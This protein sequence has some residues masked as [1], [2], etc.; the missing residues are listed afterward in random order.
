MTIPEV[1]NDKLQLFLSYQGDFLLEHPVEQLDHGFHVHPAAG[2]VHLDPIAACALL[3][4]AAPRLGRPVSDILF[5]KHDSSIFRKSY[6]PVW[7]F[8]MMAQFLCAVWPM[9][10][11]LGSSMNHMQG[12]KIV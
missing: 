8:S 1:C 10:N 5:L 12:W 11:W 7:G 4:D 2:R 3:G 9:E 6:N